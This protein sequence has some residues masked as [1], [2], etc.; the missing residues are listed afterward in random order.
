MKPYGGV[1][2]IPCKINGLAL[3][4]IFDTGASGV[5]ISLTEARFMLKNGYLSKADLLV[6]EKY[7]LANGDDVD[8]TQVLLR[9]I[10]IGGIKLTNVKA[11]I[12]HTLN[13]PLLLGQSALQKL[14]NI[15]IDYTTNTLIINPKVTSET[16]VSTVAKDEN[17]DDL[18]KK[19]SSSSAFDISGWMLASRPNVNDDSNATGKIVFRITV[20][21]DGEIV[22]VQ[23]MH[24]TISP[25]VAELYRKAVE[26]LRLRPKGGQLP[27][28]ESTG[29]ITFI[30]KQKE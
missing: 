9:N 11:S 3:E 7:S 8:G 12:L 30:I 15:F 26:R 19:S 6:A 2:A 25:P 18:F 27:P 14:G 4:F 21:S 10:E 29:T 16:V 1:Y 24:S 22:R 20:D 5:S 17:Q 23:Q 28:P 13:A